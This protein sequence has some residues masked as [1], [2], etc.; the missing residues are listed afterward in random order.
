MDRKFRSQH[1][2]CVSYVSINVSTTKY[3]YM[4]LPPTAKIKDSVAAVAV[5]PISRRTLL[6][7]AGRNLQPTND[8]ILRQLDRLPGREGIE[9]HC[10]STVARPPELAV[11]CRL[12]LFVVACLWAR[13]KRLRVACCRQMASG[14]TPSLAGSTC[15]LF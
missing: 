4:G 10:K 6:Y 15:Q 7:I 8:S 14:L 13:V 2:H 3:V 11:R 9:G 12:V 1:E 5:H